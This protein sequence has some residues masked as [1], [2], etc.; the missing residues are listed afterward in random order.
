MNNSNNNNPNNNPNNFSSVSNY[1]T[2][3]N[4]NFQTNT[5]PWSQTITRNLCDKLY[6]RRKQGA[7]EVQLFIRE[8]CSNGF[9]KEKISYIVDFV[10]EHL[11]Y[12]S[13]P[14]YR[15]GGLISL[16]AVALA[17]GS[18]CFLFSSFLFNILVEEISNFQ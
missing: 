2:A 6:E 17:L 4:S 7:Q 12:N 14:N 8:L 3:S 1:S 9:E 18:V 16:S 11:L 5:A 13:N 10:L 15:K